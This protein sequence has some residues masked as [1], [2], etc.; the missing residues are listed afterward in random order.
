MALT[1]QEHERDGSCVLSELGKL[2]MSATLSIHDTP[3]HAHDTLMHDHDKL[4]HTHD[5]CA[6]SMARQVIS[7]QQHPSHSVH[8]AVLGTP[9]STWLLIQ[10]ILGSP[11]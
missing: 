10:L 6:N 9:V 1:H 2:A 11:V 5:P 4:M 8:Q 7:C 3:M